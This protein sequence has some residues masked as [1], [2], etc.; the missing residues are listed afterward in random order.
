MHLYHYLWYSTVINNTPVKYSLYFGI[1]K[2]K[3]H[4]LNMSIFIVPFHLYTGQT[5]RF[6][7]HHSK[8]QKWIKENWLAIMDIDVY[9]MQDILKIMGPMTYNHCL[10]QRFKKKKI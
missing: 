4:H 3:Y 1:T 6:L 8:I 2:P 9:F 10:C 5:N 7:H